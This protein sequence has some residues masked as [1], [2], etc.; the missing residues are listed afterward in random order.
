MAAMK[1]ATLQKV[2]NEIVKAIENLQRQECTL[3]EEL[4]KVNWSFLSLIKS[5]LVD[6]VVFQIE[7]QRLL[8]EGQISELKI[9]LAEVVRKQLEKNAKLNQTRET[10]Q[11]T[12]VFTL[13]NTRLGYNPFA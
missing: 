6:S 13:C 3:Q 4:T 11:E 12:Q 8:L 2:N 1:G 9:E 5:K 7:S 10:I